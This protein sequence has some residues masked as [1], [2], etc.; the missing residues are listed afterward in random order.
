MATAAVMTTEGSEGSE[1]TAIEGEGAPG[2]STP[3]VEGEGGET[4]DL[5]TLFT[6]E[7]VTAKKEAMA[8]AKAEEDRRAALTDEQ[9]AAEDQTKAEEAAKNSAPET[10][11]DFVAPEGVVLDPEMLAEFAPMA[12]ELNLSQEK[13]QKLVD[14]GS[15]M[16]QKQMDGIFAAHEQR[17]E[18]L[19]VAAKA[20]PEIGEDVKLWNP[21][22]PESASK[23]IALRAFNSIAATTPA[24]KAM[25]DET[26]IGNHP[27]FIRVFYRIGKNMREDTFVNP[28]GGDGSADKGVAKTLWPGMS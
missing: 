28:G 17:K 9:R 11:A 22:D 27:E 26:G 1:G 14:L 8:A 19:L 4:D 13:A 6:P 18:A 5:K 21:D 20:D 15:K 2:A 7:E 12:K 23:S 24:I 10:Y 16:I 3:V 25:V